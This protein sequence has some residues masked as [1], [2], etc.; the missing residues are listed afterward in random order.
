MP[1]C[2]GAIGMLR[3]KE[4]RELA[5]IYRDMS[6]AGDVSPRRLC[7]L[8]SISKTYAKLADQCELLDNIVKDEDCKVMP[9]PRS[10]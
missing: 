4:Y 5:K 8:V 3:P 1:M 2:R 9:F 10:R 7:V 6:K